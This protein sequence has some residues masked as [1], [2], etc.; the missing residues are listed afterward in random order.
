MLIGKKGKQVIKDLVKVH[1]RVK[2]ILEKYPE[3][4]DSDKLLWLAYNV[5][6]N[7]LRT[8][9]Q[10][11]DAFKQ[12]LLRPRTPMFES[13]SRSR[14]KVQEQFP[15]LSGNIEFRRAEEQLVKDWSV[16]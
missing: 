15:H 3:C 2:A 11:Y 5:Q 8:N 1:E 7:D 9:M 4:R 12:W 13:L 10:S 6:Y 16:S 14:R